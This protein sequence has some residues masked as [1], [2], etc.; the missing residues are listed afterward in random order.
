MRTTVNIADELL[1]AARV[2]AREQGVSLGAVVEAG[3][4]RELTEPEPR[5]APPP[6]PVFD[7]DGGLA[8]DIDLTSNRTLHAVMHEEED[9]RVHRAIRGE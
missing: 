1:T 6:V 4:R 3:L 5:E 7:Y 9:E 2:R 8:P